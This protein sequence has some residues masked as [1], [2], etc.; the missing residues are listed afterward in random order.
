MGTFPLAGR[1][2][3]DRPQPAGD[4]PDRQPF[5]PMQSADLRP[6]LHLQHPLIVRGG[7]IFTRNQRSFQVEPTADFAASR[8]R[9]GHDV[10][11]GP[12]KV[13]RCMRRPVGAAFAAPSSCSR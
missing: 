8:S 4:R 6:V 2:C 11:G 3:S 5:S 12:G 1:S 9:L 13:A 7:S 10:R